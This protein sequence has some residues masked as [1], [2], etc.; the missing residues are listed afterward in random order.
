M[1]ENVKIVAPLNCLYGDIRKMKEKTTGEA[2]VTSIG[3]RRKEVVMKLRHLPELITLDPE[4]YLDWEEDG[5][6]FPRQKL[7]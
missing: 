7:G 4:I 6:S 3:V 2:F 1:E 5:T